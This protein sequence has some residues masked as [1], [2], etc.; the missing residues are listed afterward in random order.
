MPNLWLLKTEPSTYSYDD[1]V[2]EGKTRWDGV[3]NPVALKNIRA[4][5]KGDLAFV[6]HTGS[7]KSVVG[8][9]EIASD[10]YPDPEANDLRIVVF[11]IAT[12]KKLRRPVAL[13]EIK[14]KKI[15]AGFD[16][17]KYSRLS[18][19]PVKETY[20]KETLKMAGEG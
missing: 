19:M 2:R 20:W 12:K 8:I 17:V 15:F 16:L 10:P 6:Y 18:V 3:T 4:M 7:E 13:A 1:L 14:S 9:A 5:K 11:D